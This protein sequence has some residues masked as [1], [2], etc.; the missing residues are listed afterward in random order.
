MTSV[1]FPAG[2]GIFSLH[3]HI[4]TGSGAHPDFIKRVLGVKH[5]GCEPEHSPP[6]NAKVKN[7]WS[8]T[9]TPSYIFMLWCLVKHRIY[10]HGMTWYLVKHRHN[11][12]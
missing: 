3:H 8:Y 6:S 7:V 11:F 2:S 10:L 4:Q 9:S 12:T 1:Q 5:P